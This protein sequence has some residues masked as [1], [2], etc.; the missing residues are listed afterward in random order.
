MDWKIKYRPTTLGDVAIPD[1][2]RKLFDGFLNG[3]Y[4]PNLLLVGPPGKGKTTI[5]KILSN[6]IGDIFVN[7]SEYSCYENMSKLLAS[8][9][10]Y[11]LDGNRRIVVIDEAEKIS[12]KAF[13]YLRGAMERYSVINT[14]IFTVND[15][16]KMDKAIL[17]RLKE[18]N[19]NFDLNDHPE[20]IEK[21]RERIYR[22]LEIEGIVLDEKVKFNVDFIIKNQR[23]DYRGL[24]GE[25]QAMCFDIN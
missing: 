17:S 24:M 20:V 3:N 21:L 13:D 5:A 2:Y 23:I 1:G 8:C 12:P 15:K 11:P 25:L 6:K 7:G 22:I 4:T 14:F 19:F 9:T 16:S 18:I 10:S